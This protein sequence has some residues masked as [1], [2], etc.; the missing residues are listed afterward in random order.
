[1]SQ[2]LDIICDTLV[3]K[4][5]DPQLKEEDWGTNLQ[6]IDYLERNPDDVGPLI[7]QAIVSSMSSR[8]AQTIHL[9]L[10]VFL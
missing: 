2:N 9:S 4:A 7:L 5:T 3:R 10:V 8:D 1:M 6:L